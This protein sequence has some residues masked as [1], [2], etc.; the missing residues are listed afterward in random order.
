MEFRLTLRLSNLTV[1]NENS[2]SEDEGVDDGTVADGARN[3]EDDTDDE[4]LCSF[5]IE[6]S[7]VN[8]FA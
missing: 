7:V 8:K 4:S 3:V 5:Y 6:N 1:S 2:W